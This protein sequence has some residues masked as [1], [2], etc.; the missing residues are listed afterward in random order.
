MLLEEELALVA[1]AKVGEQAA[2]GAL[3]DAITPKLYGY[4]VNTLRDPHLAEDV[5]QETWLKAIGAL[6]KFRP[7]GVRFSA[8]LFAIAR[9]ECRQQWRRSGRSVSL[10]DEGE[11]PDG[12]VEAHSLSDQ[13]FL[14][15]VLKKLTE[16]E[17]E[18]LQLRYLGDLTFQEIAQVLAISLISARVRVH[19]ALRKA[20]SFLENN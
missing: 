15:Q 6:G 11:I 10:E 7:Q 1:R 18:I 2:L 5:L 12:A 13:I 20:N 3:W 17:R 4:L 9:N 14:E 8:W 16:S 19:R